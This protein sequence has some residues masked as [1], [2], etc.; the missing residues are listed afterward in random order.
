MWVHKHAVLYQLAQAAAAITITHCVCRVCQRTAA[1]AHKGQLVHHWLPA[2]CHWRVPNGQ[3]P[4]KPTMAMTNGC[5]YVCVWIGSQDTAPSRSFRPD[6]ILG[7]TYTCVFVSWF[8]RSPDGHLRGVFWNIQTLVASCHVSFSLSPSHTHGA[9]FEVWN[10]LR[11][12]LL[13]FHGSFT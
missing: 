4:H 8:Q 9:S 5:L 3:A 2:V 11:S 12:A 10:S 7:D 6:G 1:R 13:L